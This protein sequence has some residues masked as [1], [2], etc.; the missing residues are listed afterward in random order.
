[1]RGTVGQV[2][3]CQRRQEQGKEEEG[4]DQLK[5]KAWEKKAG[6]RTDFLEEAW[7]KKSR[8]ADGFSGEKLGVLLVLLEKTSSGMNAIGYGLIQIL[9]IP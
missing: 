5:E 4:R 9:A 3:T 8:G 2:E 7:G 6:E 1:M